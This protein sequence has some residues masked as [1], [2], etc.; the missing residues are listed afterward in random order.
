M[1]ASE[2]IKDDDDYPTHVEVTVTTEDPRP[3]SMA[4]VMKVA[5]GNPTR[6][7]SSPTSPSAISDGREGK[8]RDHGSSCGQIGQ[9]QLIRLLTTGL[10]R[11]REYV[12][13]TVSDDRTDQLPKEWW[14]TGVAFLFALFNLIFT[15]VIITVV[16]E[17]VPDKSVSPPLPDKFFDYV[18]RV[19]WAFTVT[20][21]NG[22]ILVGLWFVQ[23]LFLKHKYDQQKYQEH[24][25]G[26]SG[27]PLFLPHWDSVHVPLYHHVH[28]HAT[29]AWKPHGLRPQALQQLHREDLE[30]SPA[31]IRRRSVSDGF[32][33]DVRGLPVQRTHS[34]VDAVVPLHQRV[35]VMKLIMFLA[36]SC[37]C[38]WP[39]T[40]FQKC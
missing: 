1:A 33:H 17:R 14:K 12:K 39:I 30:D 3:T 32:P 18:D 23:W 29:G 11:H 4:H 36:D 16:H 37:I 26:Y 7:S 5:N 28:H 10:R 38:E 27:S 24:L 25:M 35:S 8:K 21:V 15:T 34:H 2:L 9:S 19:P 40:G 22:L 31:D 6:C 13:I 20:E